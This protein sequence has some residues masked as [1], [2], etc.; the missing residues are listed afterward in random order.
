MSKVIYTKKKLTNFQNSQFSQ[1]N[2][3]SKK[4]GLTGIDISCLTKLYSVNS[5]TV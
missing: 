3:Q 2:G 5:A 1:L 4:T